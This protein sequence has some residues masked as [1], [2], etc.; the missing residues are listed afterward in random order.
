MYYTNSVIDAEDVTRVKFVREDLLK[1]SSQEYDDYIKNI[2][3]KRPLTER[4]HKVSKK[5]RRL[6]KNREYAQIS[7]NKKKTEYSQ[8]STQID[9]LNQYNSELMDRVNQLESENKRLKE[10]NSK[11]MELSNS[12]PPNLF[13]SLP[14]T[15]TPPLSQSPQLS[16]PLTP[17]SSEDSSSFD[18]FSEDYTDNLFSPDWSSLTS[19]FT[20]MAVFFCLVFFVPYSPDYPVLPQS[21]PIQYDYVPVQ[22]PVKNLPSLPEYR[23][24]PRH[25]LNA[26]E[27]NIIS[28]GSTCTGNYTTTTKDSNTLYTIVDV[29]NDELNFMNDKGIALVSIKDRRENGT[30][31]DP[32]VRF[33]LHNK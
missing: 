31:V 28:F 3:L 16:P 24:N 20:F 33:I 10:E 2:S 14:L 19:K 17:P 9:Q 27:D 1:F 25:I 13:S 11:L 32:F 30:M 6:I 8:L 15:D 23:R 29:L 4:E 18:L 7:R 5:Q 21:T 26:P 22:L 12:L